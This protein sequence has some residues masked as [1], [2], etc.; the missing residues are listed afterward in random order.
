MKPETFEQYL[1][2]R[3][4]IFS[5]KITANLIDNTASNADITFGPL[6]HSKLD[7]IHAYVKEITTLQR[8]RNEFLKWKDEVGTS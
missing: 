1:E 4:K 3:E 2:K 7:I 8:T 6:E 5:D